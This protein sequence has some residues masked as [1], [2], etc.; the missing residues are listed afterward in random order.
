MSGGSRGPQEIEAGEAAAETTGS[1]RPRIPRVPVPGL[2]RGGDQ[3]RPAT[4]LTSAFI[5]EFLLPGVKLGSTTGRD[6]AGTP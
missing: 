2:V 1:A 5:S 4:V 3:K 6:N